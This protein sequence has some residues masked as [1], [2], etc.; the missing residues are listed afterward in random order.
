M[1][2]HFE[3]IKC[4]ECGKVQQ[5]IVEHS[6]PF[7]TYVH[8]CVSCG[9]VIMESEWNRLTEPLHDEDIF[10]WL[11]DK[12]YQTET[13][14]GYQMY[15]DIDMPKILNDYYEYKMNTPM[16]GKT[17]KEHLSKSDSCCC[18]QGLVCAI[19]D[20]YIGLQS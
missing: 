2:H 16:K 1:E 18:K 4:A 14:E 10:K 5:A 20:D 6:E 13:H 15:F 7:Y 12:N 19:H 17:L 8:T 11:K 3:N 9:Y